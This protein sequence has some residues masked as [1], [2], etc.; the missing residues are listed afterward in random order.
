MATARSS[1]R[2]PEAAAKPAS[3]SKRRASS[4]REP[5]SMLHIRVADSLKADAAT[6]LEAIGFTTSEAIRLFLHRVVAEQRLPL[7]LKVPNAVTRAAIEEA[8]S[9]AK[10]PTR[11]KTPEAM[12]K[13]LEDAGKR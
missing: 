4:P 13:S 1:A 10:R 11:F 9:M 12:F 5:G 7:D 2:T 6:T 8:R 3:Q